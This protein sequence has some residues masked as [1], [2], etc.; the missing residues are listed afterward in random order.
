MMIHSSMLFVTSVLVVLLRLI[1][2]LKSFTHYK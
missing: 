2:D 1:H